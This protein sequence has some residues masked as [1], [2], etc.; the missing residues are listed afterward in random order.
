VSV[1]ACVRRMV[2]LGRVR[3]KASK[4]PGFEIL[5]APH[6]Q[7]TAE[8]ARQDR[9]CCRSPGLVSGKISVGGGNPAPDLRLTIRAA[10]PE[11][12]PRGLAHPKQRTGRR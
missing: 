11:G 4:S 2:D 10:G 6:R 1:E 7:L 8:H 9:P 12:H 3:A 5:A